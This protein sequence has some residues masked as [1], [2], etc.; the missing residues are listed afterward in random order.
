MLKV[1]PVATRADRNAFCGFTAKHYAGDPNWVP[2]LKSFERELLNYKP[3]PFYDNAEI[4]TY[5]ATRDG[6][7][8]G[9]IAAIVDH[10]HNKTY[11]EKRGMFGFFECIDDESV[12]AELFKA[13]FDWLRGKG[14]TCVRGPNSPSLNQQF[15]GCLIDAFDKPPTFMMVYNKP[16]Y[17]KLI[18]SQ[19]FVK[20]QDLLAYYCEKSMLGNMN[21]KLQLVVDEAHKRFPDMVTRR[22]NTKHIKQDLETFVHLYNE[23]LRSVWGFVPMSDTEAASV[24]SSLKLLIIPELTTVIEIGGKAVAICFSMLDYN[25]IIKKINGNL[26]PFGIFY[27]LFGKRTIKKARIIGAY[28]SPEYQRWGLGIVLMSRM[29][30]DILNW[31]I[32]EAEFSYVVESNRPSRG[33]LERGGAILDKTY[34]MYDREL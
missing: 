14:M 11:S 21:P 19:G 24:A 17:A 9:R 3:H 33:T 10:L 32:T 6:Q 5:L 8:V 18:E 16:Y 2:M 20:S 27:L 4:Q 26:F 23:G 12:A 30:P 34:R 31:G 7:V 22:V 13:A 1:F 25:P 29:L 28:V 15:A